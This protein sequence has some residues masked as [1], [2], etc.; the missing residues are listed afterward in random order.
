MDQ[1]DILKVRELLSLTV[2]AEYELLKSAARGQRGHQ[3]IFSKTLPGEMAQ[4][5]LEMG[6]RVSDCLA[7]HG[8]RLMELQLGTR[9]IVLEV[10]RGE[11]GVRDFVRIQPLTEEA[12]LLS[13][14]LME[15]A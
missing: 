3:L 7:E 2:M 13:T 11:A 4:E 6:F 14:L 9:L 5:G 12:S 10:S 8:Y 15:V 1:V